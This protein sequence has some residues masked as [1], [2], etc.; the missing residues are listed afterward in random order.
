M[1]SSVC[2]MMRLGIN[3]SNQPR[4]N[5][6]PTIT[7]KRSDIGVATARR[8]LQ[9]AIES[10]EQ[11]AGGQDS[12][13]ERK[14]AIEKRTGAAIYLPPKIITQVEPFITPAPSAEEERRE[15]MTIKNLRPDE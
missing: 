5:I 9:L 6:A 8:L 1:R 7:V 14:R 10:E 12:D 4:M 3:S 15:I 2:V 13:V 11:S